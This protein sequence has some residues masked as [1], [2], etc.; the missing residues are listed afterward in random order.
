MTSQSAS[1]D[2]R[3]PSVHPRRIFPIHPLFF[4]LYPVAAL[5]AAN[6]REI[7]L[8]DSYRS[9]VIAACLASLL[10]GGLA[11]VL[12][13][14]Q[15]AALLA[16][17]WLLAF[18]SYGHVYTLL[19]PLSVGEFLIGRHRYLAPVYLLALALASWAVIRRR[20]VAPSTTVA[21]NVISSVM[22]VLPLWTVAQVVAHAPPEWRAELLAVERGTAEEEQALR[23]DIYYIVVDAYAR[24]D[25][26]RER[27]GY[28]NSAFE[29]ELRRRG[30]YVADQANANYTST[31]LSLTSSLNLDYLDR[32]GIDLSRGRYPLNIREPLARNRARQILEDQGY[33]TVAFPTGYIPTEWFDADYF[34]APDPS[35]FQSLSHRGDV[36]A[37]EAMLISTTAG[38]LLLDLDRQTSTPLE[39]FVAERLAAPENLQRSLILSAFERLQEVPSIPGPTF[40]FAH[41][42]SPHTPYFFGPAG[43]EPEDISI[44]TLYG[45]PSGEDWE[46]D[47]PKYIGQLIY[48]NQRLLEVIDA[49]LAGSQSPPIIILQSDHGPDLGIEWEAPSEG[50]LRTRVGILSAYYLPESCRDD[51]YPSVTPVNTFR[52]VLNCVAGTAFELLPDRSYY[53]PH[54]RSQPWDLRLYQEFLPDANMPSGGGG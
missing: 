34:L 24:S 12:R 42:T 17:V 23:P 54:V 29:A 6:I 25:H 16:S 19:K 47:I 37:F 41:I 50:A 43:E 49:I 2:A 3:P 4:G 52:L 35:R 27:Y 36:N 40:V 10:G 30:F 14:R 46:R 11:L 8:A 20:S 48:V 15:T 53:N 31:G 44:F 5:V 18:Y 45:A 39:S 7:E 28:D 51:L 33:A 9:L 26:L 1:V 13:Q 21:L 22:L 38:R 32:L